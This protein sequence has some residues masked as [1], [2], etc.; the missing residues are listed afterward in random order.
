MGRRG[1]PAQSCAGLTHAEEGE[2]RSGRVP[3]LSEVLGVS[4]GQK[5]IPHFVPSSINEDLGF[6]LFDYCEQCHNEHWLRSICSNPC[7]QFLWLYLSR[8]AGH[9]VI[10]LTL[11]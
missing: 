1:K 4:A 10:L 3:G 9:T 5:H 7:F 8:I 2:G 6:Y 11:P